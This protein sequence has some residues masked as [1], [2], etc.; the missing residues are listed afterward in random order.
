[1]IMKIAI[2]KLNDKVLKTT[3]LDKKLKKI[4]DPEIIYQQDFEGSTVDAEKILDDKMKELFPKKEEF[5][6][7]IKLH[8]FFNKDNGYSITSINSEIPPGYIPV[9]KEFIENNYLKSF[10]LLKIK[11][12]LENL[13][14]L[15]KYITINNFQDS[16]EVLDWLDKI[17]EISVRR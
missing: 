17:N 2:Y 8:Y 9:T 12:S 6:E 1:M 10:L 15:W 5:T 11:E 7:D 13:E 14:D 16:Q 3:N 4:K